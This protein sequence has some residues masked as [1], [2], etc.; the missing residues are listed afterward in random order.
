MTKTSHGVNELNRRRQAA[1]AMGG[2]DK[3]ARLQEAGRLNVRQWIAGLL[4]NGKFDEQG[5]LAHSNRAEVR[6][7]TPAD[8]KICGYGTIESR[9]VAVCADDVTVLAGAGG[10]IGTL[11][12]SKLYEYALRRGI[13]YITL[14][15]AGGGRIPDIMGAAGMMSHTGF[16]TPRER[17]MPHIAAIMGECYGSPAWDA[18]R[19]DIVIQVKGSVMAVTS[20]YVLTVATGETALP[21]QL[22]G[23]EFHARQTGLVDLVAEDDQECL[24]L[25]RRVLSYLP[26]NATQLPPVVPCQE[27]RQQRLDA[28]LD[29]VPE[30][31][32]KTYDMHHVIELI[33]DPDTVLEL[34]PLYDGSLIT[35]LA[36]L[37][38]HV[39]GLMANNPQVGAG[40][41]R[42]G[43]CEKGAAFIA[44]CDAYHIPLIFLHDTPGFLVGQA[45]EDHKIALKIISFVDALIQ[46][47]VPRVS[48]IIRKSY[49]M[50]HLNMAGA[51]MGCDQLLAWP[52]AEVSFMG[53]EVAINVTHGRKLA[54]MTPDD[55]AAAK[56]RLLSEMAAANQL[57]EAA[58]LN[59]IDKIIDPAD[60]RKELIAALR[61]ARG[62]D[63]KAGRSQRKIAN[64]PTMW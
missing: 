60:T 3:I 24:L 55:A 25:I 40:A 17:R 11:K 21:E 36:R 39:V 29:I 51:N 63:G 52:T 30:D 32:K 45:A 22:G 44:L 26:G 59:F 62:T 2:A 54:G 50:A 61:R 31:P 19:A 15:V 53:P 58:G 37:D 28:L 8:G 12:S 20:P 16:T 48:V 38:G 1:L 4:D 13:P 57:W 33:A 9:E 5:L 47:T 23:W 18:A 35:S 64:W 41:M 43:A 7:R 49:G 27:D 10:H 42:W 34:K 46:S 56:E 14:G 6:D